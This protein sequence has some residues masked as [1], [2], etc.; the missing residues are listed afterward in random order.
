[1]TVNW[2]SLAKPDDFIKPKFKKN[3]N[4]PSSGLDHQLRFDFVDKKTVLLED[5]SLEITGKAR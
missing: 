1:M 3:N 4:T 2:K 5:S